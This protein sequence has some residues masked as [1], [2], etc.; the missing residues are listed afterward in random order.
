LL[1]GASLALWNLGAPALSASGTCLNVASPYGDAEDNAIITVRFP[2]A[3][4]I[5]E[6]TWTTW[7]VGVP[8]GPIAYG[9]RGCLVAGHYLDAEGRAIPAVSVFTRARHGLEPADE[10]IAGRP[11]ALGAQGAPPKVRLH[12]ETGEPLHPTLQMEQTAGHGI[13]R[14]RAA[15]SA[16]SG[17]VQ[18]VGDAPGTWASP[19]AM[20]KPARRRQALATGA[21]RPTSWRR[22]RG[23]ILSPAILLPE[24]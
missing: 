15:A 8:T 16:A 21:P 10:I 12:L 13:R 5:L 3:V 22:N 11:L 1:L 4:A 6:G 14:C 2:H 17:P 20:K 9:S 24:H 19:F 7:N 18:P 23:C